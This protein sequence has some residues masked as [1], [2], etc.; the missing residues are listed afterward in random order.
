[1][2]SKCLLIV[3]GGDVDEIV[4]FNILAEPSKSFEFS[5]IDYGFMIV[6]TKLYSS[7]LS[8]F[9]AMI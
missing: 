9:L 3:T 6:P 8:K 4:E 7:E 2:R 1:M 5:R